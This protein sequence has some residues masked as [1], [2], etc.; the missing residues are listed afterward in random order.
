MVHSGAEPKGGS[1]MMAQ[2]QDRRPSVIPAQGRL[3][4]AA[5]GDQ[6][7]APHRYARLNGSTVCLTPHPSSSGVPLA[8]P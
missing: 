6:A 3:G 8:L 1:P 5:D 4:G 7:G 2:V